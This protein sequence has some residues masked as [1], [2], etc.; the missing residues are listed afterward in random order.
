MLWVVIC[1]LVDVR[2]FVLAHRPHPHSLTSRRPHARPPPLPAGPKR[3]DT[4]LDP[5]Q[6]MHVPPLMYVRRVC[7][8]HR[9]WRNRRC[10][11]TN[12]KPSRTGGPYSPPA[13]PLHVGLSAPRR[14]S[15][16]LTPLAGGPYSHP[17]R[18]WPLRSTSPLH[19]SHTSTSSRRWWSLSRGD[20]V[21]KHA[22]KCVNP[23]QPLALPRCSRW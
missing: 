3:D 4:G 16:P 5:E 21:T 9:S 20:A 22:H 2:P 23:P 18:R 13:S 10:N 7:V 6:P 8:V 14:H 17:P 12:L 15:T 11:V 1:Y 19:S